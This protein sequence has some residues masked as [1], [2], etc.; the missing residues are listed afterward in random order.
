[1]EIPMSKALTPYLPLGKE[2]DIS[3]DQRNWSIQQTSGQNEPRQSEIGK[4]FDGIWHISPIFPRLQF[5]DNHVESYV[6]ALDPEPAVWDGVRHEIVGSLTVLRM[7]RDV[8]RFWSRAGHEFLPRVV[9]LQ[10]RCQ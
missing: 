10:A 6:L 9:L 8:E 2:P 1:M 5:D 4:W 7:Q 3:Q